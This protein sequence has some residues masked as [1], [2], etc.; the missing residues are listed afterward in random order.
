MLAIE[1]PWVQLAMILRFQHLTELLNHGKE[2]ILVLHYKDHIVNKTDVLQAQLIH[3]I[4]VES[5]KVV[6]HGVLPQ[7]MP[8]CPTD[9]VGFLELRFIIG[10]VIPFLWRGLS[11]T[12]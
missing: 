1:L 4:V 8:Y 6:V 3:D 2:R 11:V 12:M 9:I 5:V 10:D 7:K